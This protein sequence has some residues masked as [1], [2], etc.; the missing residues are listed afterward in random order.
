MPWW[1]PCWQSRKWNNL[2][3]LLQLAGTD[4]QLAIAQ[5]MCKEG[6]ALVCFDRMSWRTQQVTEAMKR[7]D[8]ARTAGSSVVLLQSGCTNATDSH[9]AWQLTTDQLQLQPEGAPSL[10][11]PAA[12]TPPHATL[13]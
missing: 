4:S 9:D 6:A 10:V 3:A 7:F 1:T 8:S 2:R 5:P 11:Q 12:R 13:L